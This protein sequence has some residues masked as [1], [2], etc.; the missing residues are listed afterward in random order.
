MAWCQCTFCRQAR[1]LA[2]FF[3]SVKRL[4][5]GGILPLTR[6]TT[7]LPRLIFICSFLLLSTVSQERQRWCCQFLGFPQRD[8]SQKE[9]LFYGQDA[10]LDP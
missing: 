6:S 2:S 1:R 8:A 9:L 4:V 5:G 3:R 10:A 7:F